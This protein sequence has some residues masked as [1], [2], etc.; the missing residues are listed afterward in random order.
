MGRLEWTAERVAKERSRALHA[1]LAT[2]V[3]RSPWHRERLADVDLD[4]LS[5]V[6]IPSLPVMT[7]TDLMSNFD[8]LVTDRR[9]TA[10]R[11][12][13]ISR[14]RAATRT[15]STSTTSW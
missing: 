5:E 12:N 1:L 3:A 8:D 15:S 4:E 7:K 2:A 11:A 10:R 14:R 9:I 13:A 6:H